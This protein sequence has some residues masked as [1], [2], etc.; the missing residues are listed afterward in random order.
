MMGGDRRFHIG[1]ADLVMAG[2]ALIAFMYTAA[3]VYSMSITFDEA[4][5]FKSV[6]EPQEL[7][8]YKHFSG[9][10]YKDANNHLLNTVSMR[11]T[12]WI[13]GYEEWSLRL[14]V[15]CAHLL[16]LFFTWRLAR[17]LDSPMIG[18]AMFTVLNFNPFV[19]DFFSIARGY[20]LAMGLAAGSL[21]YFS[22]YFR[23]GCTRS[24]IRGLW[25]SSLA[26]FANLSFLNLYC[27]LLCMYLAR[28]IFLYWQ[29]SGPQGLWPFI[30]TRL[31]GD[32]SRVAVNLW[33]TFVINGV[34]IAR[35]AHA[36]AL[37]HGTDLGLWAGTVQSLIESTLYGE[38]YAIANVSLLV[39]VVQA[40]L[41]TLIVVS[42]ACKMAGVSKLLGD[43]TLY[44]GLLLLCGLSVFLQNVLFSV[45][46]PL[47]R[48]A[49]LFFPLY[50]LALFTGI[51]T[52]ATRGPGV[53]KVMSAFF[54]AAVTTAAGAHAAG[55]MNL[56]STYLWRYDEESE[57]IMRNIARD[58]SKLTGEGPFVINIDRE[59][60]FQASFNYYI[61]L[62][63]L[64]DFAEVV[65][66]RGLPDPG[67]T[68][69]VMDQGMIELDTAPLIS[70][71]QWKK[72]PLKVMRRPAAD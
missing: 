40:T 62:L 43:D 3:R 54:L 22:R 66:K 53:V 65:R 60:R 4:W 48:T 69:I 27:A 10:F 36:G 29:L 44:L 67:A 38:H 19:L 14:P 52:L 2:L 59:W 55:T 31:K 15:F 35:L 32:R 28:E 26:V 5:A 50:V 56:E 9:L 46:Y 37:I 63:G 72:Q 20:G 25:F 64:N 70:V 16:F 33:V 21:W 51:G 8:M 68:Y 11:L 13:F 45:P 71:A 47:D 61:F 58:V 12:T 57:V 23:T 17:D 34:F 24:L 49:L 7:S 18:I 1:Y 30:R 42:V 41:I 39:P 6:L